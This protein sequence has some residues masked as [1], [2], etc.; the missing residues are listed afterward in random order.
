MQSLFYLRNGA[1]KYPKCLRVQKNKKSLPYNRIEK[2]CIFR[3]GKVCS[4]NNER[5]RMF[6]RVSTKLRREYSRIMRL[7]K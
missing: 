5:R 2:V 3:H 7:L 4:Q 1:E 6:K